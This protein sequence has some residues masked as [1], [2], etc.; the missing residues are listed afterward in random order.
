MHPTHGNSVR[1]AHGIADDMRV[2]VRHVPRRPSSVSRRR[3]RAHSRNLTTCATIG[4]A[5]ADGVLADT[6]RDGHRPAFNE[7]FKAKGID[8]DW[9]VELYG[10]LLET[11]SGES[12]TFN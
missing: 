7:A 12:P 3:D 5:R 10:E 8:C 2:H 11:V 9:D 1:Q 4:C 6:E